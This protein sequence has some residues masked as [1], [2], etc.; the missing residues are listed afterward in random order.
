MQSHI[1]YFIATCKREINV[2]SLSN[3]VLIFDITTK[4]HLFH[5]YVVVLKWW[6][7]H[8]CTIKVLIFG[9]PREFE[10]LTLM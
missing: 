6:E 5:D 4:I 8:D 2:I 3:K 1:I 7:N 10:G 9:V